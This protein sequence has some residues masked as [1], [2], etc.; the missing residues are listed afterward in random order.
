MRK[1]T[2]LEKLKLV[3]GK[4]DKELNPTLSHIHIQL[5]GGSGTGGKFG[6]AKVPYDYSDNFLFNSPARVTQEK[7]YKQLEVYVGSFK[8][9]FIKD[10]NVNQDE[11]PIKNLYLWSENKG[12]GKTSTAAAL[13]NEYMFMSW[14]ASVIR[15]TNMKQPPAYFLDVNSF[16][17][18]YNKFTR[19]GIAKDIAEKTS[20]EY[21]EMME[22]AESAPLVVFD[23]IGN[24]S[25]TEAFRADLHDIINK[26]MVNKLPSIFTSNHPIDYLEQVFDERLADRVRERTIVYH[27][28]GDSHR[29]I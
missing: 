13:L 26:R 28:E 5:C 4:T 19:N 2:L 9:D 7:I 17:T 1:Q 22:L 27:F 20:R 21:Y 10:G 14:Q 25:A 11:R 12:N 8:R 18:L 16:Q 23:E 24:R 3:T 6:A 15:K 29:G